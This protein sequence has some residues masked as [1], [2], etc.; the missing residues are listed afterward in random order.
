M[1]ALQTTCQRCGLCSLWTPLDELAPVDDEAGAFAFTVCSAC[2]K[3]WDEDDG[4]DAAD[5]EF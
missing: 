2:K 5:I 1:F 4:D 3:R